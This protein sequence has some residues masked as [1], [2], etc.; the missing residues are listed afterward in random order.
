MKFLLRVG[1]IGLGKMGQLHFLNALRIKDVKVVAIADKSKKNRSMAQKYQVKTYDDYKKLID[2][3]KLDAV[4]ISLPN[5]LRE[6]SIVCAV[7]R[8]L[9]IFVD[10]PLARTLAEATRITKTVEKQGVRM[11]SGVNYRYFDSVQRLKSMLD[12]GR[13]GDVVIATSDLILNGPLGHGRIPV[14]VP[15]WWLNKTKAGGGALLDLGYH[16]IDIMN[17]IFGDLRVEYSSLEHRF[18]LPVEDGATVVLRSGRSKVTCCINAGWFSKSIFPD[19]N[20]RVNLHGTVGYLSTDKFTPKHLRAHAVKEAAHNLLR[21]ATGRKMK[22]LS[23]TYFYHSFYKILELFFDAVKNDIEFP[24]SLEEEMDVMRI[25]D[26]VYKNN[27]VDL[28]KS[29]MMPTKITGYI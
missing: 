6:D 14:P 26:D 4:I 22:Y 28:G 21:K 18:Q 15:E 9:D 19:F 3:E 13:I 7:E 27:G 1:I 29:L 2:S 5:F 17:W 20:F 10:K 12:E 25:I 16:L 11:M 24:V 8:N 23:Y